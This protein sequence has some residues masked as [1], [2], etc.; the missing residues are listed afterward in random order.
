MFFISVFSGKIKFGSEGEYET[1]EMNTKI[2]KQKIKIPRISIN[3]L[4]VKISIV[5]PSFFI[6][7]LMNQIYH[8]VSSNF[9]C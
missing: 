4:I 3:L 9:C 1:K 7:I 2:P 5:F 8:F 6:S